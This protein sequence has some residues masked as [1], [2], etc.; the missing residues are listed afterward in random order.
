MVY[1]QKN[2]MLPWCHVQKHGNPIAL[3]CLVLLFLSV[4]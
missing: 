3:H 1:V 4:L 2:M